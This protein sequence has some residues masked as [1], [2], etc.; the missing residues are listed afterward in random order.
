[1]QETITNANLLGNTAA[2]VVAVAAVAILALAIALGAEQI[3]QLGDVRVPWR[4]LMAGRS[5]QALTLSFRC[6][7]AIAGSYLTGRCRP[8][9]EQQ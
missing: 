2:V 9:N 7:W 5:L 8:I 6:F 3:L 1:M 4:Q